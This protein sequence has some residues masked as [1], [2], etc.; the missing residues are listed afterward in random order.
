MHQSIED[1]EDMTINEIRQEID[2]LRRLYRSGD[3]TAAQ[4]I[5]LSELQEAQRQIERTAR[6]RPQL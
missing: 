6:R 1:I 2:A 5:R 3:I 4:A